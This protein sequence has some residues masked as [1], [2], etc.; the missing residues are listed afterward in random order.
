MEEPMRSPNCRAAF[1]QI[2]HSCGFYGTPKFSPPPSR[3]ARSSVFQKSTIVNPD[4]IGHGWK[5]KGGKF[6]PAFDKIFFTEIS[7]LGAP[8]ISIYYRHF[9][10]ALRTTEPLFCSQ[11]NC[12]SN[13]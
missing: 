4:A 3:V 1:N 2:I 6:A 10:P 8:P 11:G 13:V 9:Y 5:K 12:H 7:G